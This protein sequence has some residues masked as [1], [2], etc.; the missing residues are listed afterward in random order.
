M[1][2]ALK[3]QDVTLWVSEMFYFEILYF[4]I[5]LVIG[6]S[7]IFKNKKDSHLYHAH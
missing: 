4:K 5:F 3:T 1:R 6:K 7:V 2:W